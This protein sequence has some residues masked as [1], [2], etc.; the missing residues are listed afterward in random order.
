MVCR[1]VEADGRVGEWR[2]LPMRPTP[3]RDSPS[4][5]RWLQVSI[6]LLGQMDQVR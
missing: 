1:Q 4:G 3:S 5:G 2:T 6:P